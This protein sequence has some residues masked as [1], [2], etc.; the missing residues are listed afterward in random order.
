ML[1]GAAPKARPLAAR[2]AALLGDR[3]FLRGAPVDLGLRLSVLANARADPA[4]NRAANRAAIARIRAEAKRLERRVPSDTGSGRS[5]AQARSHKAAPRASTP[6]ALAALAF[7]DRIGL[8]RPGDAPRWI[9][10]GG[11][12]AVMDAGDPLAGSRLLVALDLDGDARDA[13]IRL[14]APLTETELREVHGARITSR[15]LCRWSRRERRVEARLQETLGALVLDDRPWPDAP[16]E[17]IAEAALDGVRDLGIGCLGLTPPV[18][19]LRR[20]VELLRRGDDMPDFSDEGLMARADDWLLP[21]LSRTRSAADLKALDLMGP[22]RQQ[23]DWDQ[24]QRLD[25]L[26]PAQ[27]TTPLGRS[28][29]I[30]Y[31]DET[32]GIE[33]RLQE[34]FGLTRHP[35][36]GPDA[37][38]LRITLMSPARR[39]VQVTMDL[40]GFWQTSY[41]DVRKDMRGRYPRHPWPEDPTTAAPTTRAKPRKG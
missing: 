16:P 33:V 40:P 24:T 36:V 8:R 21:Y 37:R 9:L 25:R 31:D 30:D 39:P 27:F 6:G 15:Q 41:A 32:P 26:A 19:R 22:L 20:R 12:G 35:T 10:S 34:M 17:A 18:Q 2:M 13:R 14:A 38:P 3:D 5:A 4:A 28:V 7:P 11:K 29:P 23:L 1:S